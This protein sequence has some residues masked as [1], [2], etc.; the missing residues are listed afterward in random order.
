MSSLGPQAYTGRR[1]RAGCA[2]QHPSSWL[3]AVSTWVGGVSGEGSRGGPNGLQ[4]FAEAGHGVAI[5]REFA[6]GQEAHIE[7]GDAVKGRPGNLRAHLFLAIVWSHEKQAARRLRRSAE[8]EV[9]QA[10][11]AG[12]DAGGVLDLERG[13]DVTSDDPLYTLPKPSCSIS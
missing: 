9:E 13:G 6:V 4:S 8:R 11:D 2:L 10:D 5:P 12:V 7:L 1:T 3:E